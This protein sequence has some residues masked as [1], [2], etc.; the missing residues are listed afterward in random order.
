MAARKYRIDPNFVV[1]EPTAATFFMLLTEEEY[2]AKEWHAALDKWREEGVRQ[3]RFTIVN[4]EYPHPPYPH[5]VWVEGWTDKRARMLPFGEAEA[6]DKGCS[7]PLT[8]M[9]TT[10]AQ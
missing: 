2:H 4:D 10:D 6:P 1:P 8:A 3:L 5:G 7:P 9:P